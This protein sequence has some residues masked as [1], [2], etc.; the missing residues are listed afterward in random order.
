MIVKDLFDQLVHL[1][2]QCNERQNIIQ[3]FSN[4]VGLED[5]I[6]HKREEEKELKLKIAELLNTE[7]IIV[8]ENK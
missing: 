3:W 1:N 8:K 6:D 2:A 7:I 5:M 4:G